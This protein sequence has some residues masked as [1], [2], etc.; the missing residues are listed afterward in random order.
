MRFKNWHHILKTIRVNNHF[1]NK[2][3]FMSKKNKNKDSKHQD[4]PHTQMNPSK[5]V[6]DNDREK[7]THG[8]HKTN[9]NPGKSSEKQ[10][11]KE[12]VTERQD[13]DEE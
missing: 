12:G 11:K 8:Q 4:S 7:E 2:N 3:N 1:E 5:P 13:M 6:H 9:E 10:S